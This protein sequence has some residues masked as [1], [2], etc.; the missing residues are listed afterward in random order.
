MSY[1]LNDKILRLLTHSSCI[2]WDTSGTMRCYLYSG[3]LLENF[4]FSCDGALFWLNGKR[5]IW[6]A[7][8]HCLRP[9]VPSLHQALDGSHLRPTS[10]QRSSFCPRPFPDNHL[11]VSCEWQVSPARAGSASLLEGQLHTTT[12]IT[13]RL[14]PAQSQRAESRRFLGMCLVQVVSCFR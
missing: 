14:S 3:I 7:L 6:L 5:W 2:P 11:V 10:R 4:P 12:P 1:L 13:G 8:Q 9:F